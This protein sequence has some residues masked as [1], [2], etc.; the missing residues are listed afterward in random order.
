MKTKIL[1]EKRVYGNLIKL[2]FE[3]RK[4]L[5]E[6]SEKLEIDIQ[7]PEFEKEWLSIKEIETE[8]GLSRKRIMKFEKEGLK[9]IRK[10]R[11][12][13]II[14]RRTELIKFLTKK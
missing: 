9:L 3:T 11:N 10:T 5:R 6:L 2:A 7:K 13:G 12:G 1:V 4:M 8:F 14:I